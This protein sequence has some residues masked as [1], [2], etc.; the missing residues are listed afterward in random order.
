V[1]HRRDLSRSKK[2]RL[3]QF[4]WRIRGRSSAPLGAFRTG[5]RRQAEPYRRVYQRTFTDTYSKVGL[6]TASQSEK[7]TAAREVRLHHGTLV[8]WRN[9]DA[10]SSDAPDDE[11]ECSQLY[12]LGY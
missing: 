2:P 3:K 9:A 10:T 11:G 6:G 7:S 12:N 1:L 5:L 4:V 8:L